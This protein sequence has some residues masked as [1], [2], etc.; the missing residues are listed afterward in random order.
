MA[1][2]HLDRIFERFYRVQPDRSRKS[3]GTGLGLSIVKQIVQAHGE[4]IHV[5][6]VEGSG[7]IF[8]FY[9]PLVEIPQPETV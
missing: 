8:T 4:Q 7:T 2:E 3:G 5:E 1:T 9:L 6:S